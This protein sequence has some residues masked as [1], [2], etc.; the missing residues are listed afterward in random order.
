MLAGDQGPWRDA[1]PTLYHP[2]PQPDGCPPVVRNLQPASRQ[3]RPFDTARSQPLPALFAMGCPGGTSPRACEADP[4]PVCPIGSQRATT[5]SQ[6]PQPEP[7]A[8]EPAPARTSPQSAASQQPY[9]PISSQYSHQQPPQPAV[10]PQPF[11][12]SQQPQP[13]GAATQQPQPFEAAAFPARSAW[14]EGK[15]LDRC[16][17]QLFQYRLPALNRKPSQEEPPYLRDHNDRT[18][19]GSNR[20]FNGNRTDG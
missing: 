4:G 6:L 14:I 19:L 13:F 2:S 3:A 5:V 8:N 16:Q 17:S 20:V 11:D 12:P 18:F 10:R 1:T 15:P 9:Q 7:S